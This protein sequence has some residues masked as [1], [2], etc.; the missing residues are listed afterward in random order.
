[1]DPANTDIVKV[2]PSPLLELIIRDGWYGNIGDYWDP[3][4]WDE[5][6]AYEQLLRAVEKY[7]N[8]SETATEKSEAT[9]LDQLREILRYD[10]IPPRLEEKKIRLLKTAIED[11]E[12]RNQRPSKSKH[13]ILRLESG[14]M[15][16]QVMC[17][18]YPKLA[19]EPAVEDWR[20]VAGSS[21]FQTAVACG[22]ERSLHVMLGPVLEEATNG[23]RGSTFQLPIQINTTEFMEQLIIA[24][25]S[26]FSQGTQDMIVN[27][28]KLLADKHPSLLNERIWEIAATAPSPD[29]VRYLL[30]LEGSIFLTPVNIA[31]A[32]DRGFV[33]RWKTF[34][35]SLRHAAFSAPDLDLLLEILSLGKVHMIEQ[36]FKVQYS[37]VESI[38]EKK[39]YN[40]LIVILK[41]L[42]P[43]S[44]IDTGK[45]YE[46]LRSVL[47][48]SM[49]RDPSMEIQGIREVLEESEV[50]EM[51]FHL[52][53]FKSDRE[54]ESLTDYVRGLKA[55]TDNLFR[56]ERTLKQVTISE[57]SGQEQLRT[58]ENMRQEH[59]EVMDIFGWLQDK[60]VQQVLR[61]YVGDRLHC[62]HADEDVAACVN[63]FGV[64]VLHWRKLDLYLKNM[65]DSSIE[66][67]HLYSS[68]NRS[69][70]DQ[71]LC[72]L[73]RFKQ[74]KKL[75]VYLV[76]DVIK[77]GLLKKLVEDL[78]SDLHLLN[79]KE[80]CSW[81][82]DEKHLSKAFNANSERHIDIE[83]VQIWIREP[84]PIAVA[85]Q[86]LDNRTSDILSSN[87]ARF[88]QR[89]GH[90]NLE[91]VGIKK[92]KVALIDS[93]VVLVGPRDDNPYNDIFSTITQRIVKGISLVSRD[94]E[95]HSWWHATEPHGTQ[96]AALI[97]TLNPLCDLYVVKV[98][99]SDDFGVTGYNVAKAIDWAR[100]KG[101]D[102]IS[103]SLVTFSD[104]DNKMLDAIKA[105][106]EDDIVITC[107]IADEGNMSA[108]SVGES[109]KDVLS[110]A[111]CDRWG[112]LLP[113]SR[114][115]GF[116][117]QFLGHNVYVGRVPYLESSEVIE[118]S[119]V[120]TA[121]AAG[122]A[123]LIL[124]CARI[125]SPSLNEDTYEEDGR[126][127]SWRCDTVKN[128]FDSMSEGKWV[129]LD[130]LCGPGKLRNFYH[131]EQLVKGSFKIG[132]GTS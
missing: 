66:E 30:E 90:H 52:P 109:N 18:L 47:V 85:E 63:T 50:Y 83:V 16:V 17:H 48:S 23:N 8:I 76:K 114:K 117:Y 75:T 6:D 126:R 97:C 15:L 73:P 36:T 130:N 127:R 53:Q 29:I 38:V 67:L 5:D 26:S 27:L 111:A 49:V 118:G 91:H 39:G 24:S 55:K 58:F 59:S 132:E 13:A 96:M 65:T 2:Q 45:F 102:V 56:F 108:R 42:K 78:N 80:G 89:F 4:H 86:S 22:S 31:L 41:K 104:Y 64:R 54:N 125:S 20:S 37:L 62:P 99:E 112:N 12:K 103:L 107:S 7:Q 34:P 68:G 123:S 1:M 35:E 69:V 129:I 84:E 82:S 71:W 25:A 81:T 19:F 57:L 115:T 32:F 3:T 110:I 11:F 116:D 131:F 79:T 119:S 40:H 95:E 106:R 21:A 28:F 60:G 98:A 9:L 61:L 43:K 88:V 51:S 72:Q 121:I 14:F 101:V 113:Q 124:A 122:M 105:A 128:R 94:G 87:L 120:S 77:S 10:T 92:T 33:P 74:L 93:G 70:H 44:A 100:S 46:I